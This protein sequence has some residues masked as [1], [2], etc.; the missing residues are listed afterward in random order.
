MPGRKRPVAQQVSGCL[1]TPLFVGATDQGAV[2]LPGSLH[3]RDADFAA[4]L[5]PVVEP[6]LCRQN[7]S[8]VRGVGRLFAGGLRRVKQRQASKPGRIFEPEAIT[9]R[10]PSPHGVAHSEEILLEDRRIV[11]VDDSE[12]RAHRIN[13]PRIRRPRQPAGALVGGT[14][15]DHWL[16]L[17]AL[18]CTSS[19]LTSQPPRCRRIGT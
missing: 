9:I 15:Q 8:T 11:P 2:G 3:R 1:R 14:W 4:K 5:I 10:P 17:V 6:R 18:G 7:E 12:Y 19:R 16:E 13:Y